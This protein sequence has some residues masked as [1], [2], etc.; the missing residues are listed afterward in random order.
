MI[1]IPGDIF[2]FSGKEIYIRIV[3]QNIPELN[4][5]EDKV[6][7]EYKIILPFPNNIIIDKI[8]L[9]YDLDINCLPK[10]SKAYMYQNNKANYLNYELIKENFGLFKNGL[11]FLRNEE[12]E[13]E[14]K[15]NLI[16]ESIGYKNSLEEYIYKTR[17]KI[18]VKGELAE[19]ITKKE[20]EKLIDEMDKLMKWLYSEDKDLYN[21]TKLEQNSL[22]MKNI[23]EPIYQRFN[24]WKKLNE[25]FIKMQ[26][27]ITEKT[28]H[29]TSLEEKIKKGEIVAITLEKVNKIQKIIQ[30]EFNNL[31]MKIFQAENEPKINM[32]SIKANDVQN[33][34]NIFEQKIENI[35]KGIN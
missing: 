28:V 29:Y 30:E 2:D 24:D 32:P 18:D 19:Y 5:L 9:Y 20:K 8:E 31:E 35:I 16:K 7:Q 11:D 26:K 17:D 4:F 3:Y 15:D 1:K 13:Q 25:C 12:I 14:K 27:I 34:I 22:G 33:M 6:I 23:S 21:K 10:L